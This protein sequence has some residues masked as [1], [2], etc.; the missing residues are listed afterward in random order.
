MIWHRITLGTLGK[1]A[2]IVTDKSDDRSW[3]L[4]KSRGSIKNGNVDYVVYHEINGEPTD[5]MINKD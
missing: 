4:C 3:K 5:V 1:K 2:M